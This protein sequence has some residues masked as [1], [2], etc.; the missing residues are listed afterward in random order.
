MHYYENRAKQLTEY[1]HLSTAQLQQT[2]ADLEQQMHQHAQDLE[3]EAAA[4][5]RDKIQ[6]IENAFLGV[7]KGG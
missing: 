5:L 2:I 4:A 3:F 1:A 6:T 7:L